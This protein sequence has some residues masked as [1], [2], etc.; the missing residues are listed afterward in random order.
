MDR[1]H[2]ARARGAAIG[3]AALL[4]LSVWAPSA[5]AAPP[6]SASASFGRSHRDLASSAIRGRVNA[7]EAARRSPA[8]PRPTTTVWLSRP[9][10]TPAGAGRV[11]APS[12]TIALSAPVDATTT[13]NPPIAQPGFAGLSSESGPA[14]NTDPPDPWVAAGPDQIVQT[15][16][17][18]L[19]ITNRVGGG[20]TSVALRTFFDMGSD[21]DNT[22]PRVHYD[23]AHGRWLVT[24]V[25]FTCSRPGSGQPFGYLDLAVSDTADALGGY[26]LLRWTFGATFPDFPA[27]GTS[28]DKL[29][30]GANLFHMVPGHPN[31]CLDQPGSIFVGAEILVFDWADVVAHGGSNSIIDTTEFTDTSGAFSTPRVALQPTGTSAPLDTLLEFS[32]DGLTFSPYYLRF[33]GSAVADTVDVAAEFDLTSAAIVDAWVEPPSPIQPG[34]DVVTDAIDGRPTDAIAQGSRLVFVSTNG[35]IPAGDVELHDCVRVTELNTNGVSVTA[36][37]TLKQDFLISGTD[38]DHYFGGVGLAGD[39]MLGVVWTASSAAAGDYPSSY[40]AYQLPSDGPNK[41]S[42]PEKLKA[43]TGPYPG[44][45]WGDYVGVPAD[46]QVP[47]ALWQANQ[48]SAGASGWRTLVSQLQTGGSSYVPITPVRVLDSRPAFQIGLT[49]TFKANTPRS[50]KVAGFLVNGTPVIPSNAVA[51]TGNLAVV[52]QT[53]AG[54]ASVTPSPNANPP[55]SSVNFPVGDIRANNVTVPLSAA[56][57]LSGVYKAPGG[58]TTHLVFDVT[59]Y[60][61][62]GTTKATYATVT[63]T[64][65]LD[66]RPEWHIGLSGPFVASIPRTL[67]VAGTHGIPADAVAITANLAVVGQTSE[68]Y[69]AVTPDPVANPTTAT[70][71]FPVGD[72]RANGLTARLNGAGNLSIVYKAPT[73]TSHF[74]L[75][76]TGYYRNAPGGLQFF[77]LT[78]GR[79][80][81][82][83]PVAILS[84]LSG[85]FTSSVP[86]TVSANAHFGIPNTGVGALTG[87]LSIVNQTSPGYATITPDPDASPETATINFPVGDVRGN[88]VTVPL[89]GAFDLSFVYKAG[90]G[91]K[92]DMILDVTGYF[93]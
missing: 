62:K 90:G 46:P 58:A 89:N 65:I 85:K 86:R 79:L 29:G 26:T 93:R 10:L 38:R 51:V 52:G 40:A 87:N 20:A 55:T 17:V 18:S 39:G 3:V 83:R 27:L 37:P 33:T 88:G 67:H 72:V 34:P 50:W 30:W 15:T 78:P 16:N 8:V 14:T 91:T 28:A 92:T 49:G 68:G 2:P 80:M 43:G 24:Q 66:S 57:M 70:M 19:R 11:A 1:R 69:V 59:G 84:R 73:G 48:Y 56:G 5:S 81:D 23:S 82:T 4:T 47:N 6:A 25:A 44:Q 77:P 7:A 22:D 63:P 36:P 21:E 74:V 71:N 54:Y 32:E 35:C 31:D 13:G 61:L 42:A 53:A 76:V 64:R 9:G 12:R 41:L 75:D 45:R 60:F